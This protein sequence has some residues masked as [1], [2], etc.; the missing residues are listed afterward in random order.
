MMRKLHSS[1]WFCLFLTALFPGAMPARATVTVLSYWHMGEKDPGAVSGGS[2]TNTVDSAGG[3][4]LA[5]TP[6]NTSLYPVYTSGVAATAATNTGSTLALSITNGQYGAGSLVTSAANNFGIEC[7]VNPGSTTNS[8]AVLAYNGLR[9]NG[10]GLFQNGANFEILFGGEVFLGSGTAVAKAGT[11][12]YL[13]LVENN[14]IAT[15]YTN[16]VAAFSATST[17]ITPSSAFTVGGD[18]LY[19]DYFTGSI[20]EVRVFTFNTGAFV[21]N[22]LLYYQGAPP[23]TVTLSSDIYNE[24]AVAGS[25]SVTLTI[26]PTNAAWT[27]TANT[28]WLHLPVTNGV[29]SNTLTFTFSDNTGIPRTGTLTIAGQTVTV[30]QAQAS[31]SFP[32]PYTGYYG[33]DYAETAAVG[34]TY[35]VPITVTPNDANWTCSASASWIHV[36]TPSGTGSM[37]IQYSVDPNTNSSATVRWDYNGVSFD[38]VSNAYASYNTKFLVYQQAPT[39]GA[40]QATYLFTGNLIPFLPEYTPANASAAFRSL[41]SNDV[42]Y[43]SMTLVTGAP[44][45]YFATYACGANNITF[46][47]PTRGLVYSEPYEDFEVL[48]TSYNPYELRWDAGE[49]DSTVDM[50]FWARDF[51]NTALPNGNMPNP[52]NLTGFHGGDDFAQIIFYNAADGGATLWYA[53][54]VPIPFLNITPQGSG[55]NLIWWLTSDA[56]LTPTLQSATNLTPASVWKNVTNEPVVSGLTNSVTLPVSTTAMFYRLQVLDTNSDND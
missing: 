20:D 6:I 15:L 28:S 46:S 17:P 3:D 18:A 40:G 8:G 34:G 27:A 36:L 48:Y 44:V 33:C 5:F 39:P 38:S 49:V 11:W 43:L 19:G 55:T 31:I 41:Q 26:T 51:S 21:T 37:N 54:L 29:G 12:T 2:C 23:P 14:G 52:L 16:G 30:N 47:V 4:T 32:L 24:S 45:V 35:T 9:G 22:D 42:Y 25:D 1:S 10:W 50:T 56:T 7:W 53:N 13:A